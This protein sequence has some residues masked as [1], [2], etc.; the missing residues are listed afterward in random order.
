MKRL[1]LKSANS[2]ECMRFGEKMVRE[3]ERIIKMAERALKMEPSI[4]EE[5]EII[6]IEKIERTSKA[7]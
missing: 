6:N 1:T 7:N 3:G 4:G 5:I 2:K